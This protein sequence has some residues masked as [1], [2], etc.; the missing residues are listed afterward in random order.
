MKKTLA[1]VA[2]LTA[3]ALGAAAQQKVTLNPGTDKALLTAIGHQWGSD[4]KG[5]TQYSYQLRT[6]V[7]MN[8][9]DKGATLVQI[10]F[11]PDGKPIVTP[12]SAPQP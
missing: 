5:L 6:D 12:I 1:L 9:D 11:G 3:L 8:G 4:L 10:A 7:N 2:V